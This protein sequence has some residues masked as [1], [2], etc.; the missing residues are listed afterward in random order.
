MVVSLFSLLS[1]LSSLLSPLSTLHSPLSSLSSLSS[2]FYLF[3]LLSFLILFVNGYESVCLFS[4]FVYFV[5]TFKFKKLKISSKVS[6][7][8]C[9]KC[10]SIVKGTSIS[11]KPLDLKTDDVIKIENW[12][13]ILTFDP[14]TFFLAKVEDKET[15]KTEKLQ[16]QVGAYPTLAGQNGAYIFM[17]DPEKTAGLNMFD[18]ADVTG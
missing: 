1:P 11:T 17:R 15:G 12:R 7:V 8:R 6:V 9:L 14:K 4:L 3:T 5:E 16:F 10:T 18:I 13:Q 2:L